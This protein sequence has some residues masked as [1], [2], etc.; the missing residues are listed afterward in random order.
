MEGVLPERNCAVK[1]VA[2]NDDG[3]D[4]ERALHETDDSCSWHGA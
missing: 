2:V 4:P 3:T 1:L